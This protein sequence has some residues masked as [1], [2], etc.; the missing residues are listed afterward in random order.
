VRASAVVALSC[1]V[2]ST[3]M[4]YRCER[5]TWPIITISPILQAAGQPSSYTLATRVPDLPGCDVTTQTVLVVDF[6]PGTDA[7]T[8]T[9]GTVNG[10]AIRFEST[11][12]QTLVFKSPVAVAYD[13]PI[14]IV[15]HGITTR[16]SG[17]GFSVRLA[18]TGVKNG[19]IR[20]GQSDPF[21]VV[22]P[23]PTHT[24]SRTPTPTVTPR[25]TK[26]RRPPLQFPT[27]TPTATPTRPAGVCPGDCDG[28]GEVSI[29]EVIVLA[30]LA[31]SAVPPAT[32]PG[33]D[34]DGNDSI[35][36]DEIL[37]A[38]AAALS[39]CELVSQVP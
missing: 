20:A 38:V 10:S 24:P 15:L 21:D 36:I 34:R 18:A 6:P 27:L 19:S 4:A 39:G 17:E 26:G 12:A 8:V 7:T 11:S 3:G 28:S 32:C 16:G 2:P 14:V 13:K 5:R 37:A 30:N 29:A 22:T 33:G 25:R 1:L 23:T 9:G 31:A 35:S